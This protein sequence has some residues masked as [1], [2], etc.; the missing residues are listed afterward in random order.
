MINPLIQITPVRIKNSLIV[1]S[2]KGD[3]YYDMF[4]DDGVLSLGYYPSLSKVEQFVNFVPLLYSHAARDELYESMSDFYGFPYIW[5]SGSGSE[6]NELAL[7]IIRKH[8]N[9]NGKETGHYIY[10]Y[11]GGFHGRT[12]GSLS[13]TDCYNRDGFEPLLPWIKFFSHPSEIQSDVGG[14]FMATVYGYHDLMPYP[15][16][17]WNQIANIVHKNDVLLGL[18]EVKVGSGRWGNHFFA[19]TNWGL[20]PDIVTLGKGVA[21]GR[22][23]ALTLMNDEAQSVLKE[24]DHFVTCAGRIA[25]LEWTF[26]ASKQIHSHLSSTVKRC[27]KMKNICNKY[28]IFPMGESNL[29]GWNCSDP[30]KLQKCLMNNGILLPTFGYNWIMMTWNFNISIYD[31]EDI[32]RKLENALEEYKNG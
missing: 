31:F 21:A 22:G 19:F 12:F 27:H 6:A 24:R 25:D 23:V 1:Q 17:F 9:I 32:C 13:A 18:D 29:I 4:N 3:L 30:A 11:K 14:I 10:C 7:K 28:G 26:N 20:Q 5:M 2:A 15:Q 16:D 8:M